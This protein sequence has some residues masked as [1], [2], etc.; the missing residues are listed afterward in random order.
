MELRNG[1]G[2]ATDAKGLGVA[3]LSSGFLLKNDV[4]LELEETLLEASFLRWV[5]LSIWLAQLA[6]PP[7]PI[8]TSILHESQYLVLDAVNSEGCYYYRFSVVS[9]RADELSLCQD[10]TFFDFAIGDNVK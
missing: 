1:E 4:N 3:A 8:F 5:T 7:K 2:A 9:V 6:S 10:H